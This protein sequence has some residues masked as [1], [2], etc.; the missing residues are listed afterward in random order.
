MKSIDIYLQESAGNDLV[1]FD[2]LESHWNED[3]DK[4]LDKW[5]KTFED[6]ASKDYLNGAGVAMLQKLK[7]LKDTVSDGEESITSIT[8]I[9]FTSEHL[10][11]PG[12]KY[13]LDKFETGI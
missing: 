8:D 4:I 10:T 11:G 1:V 9:D 5:L 2:K 3:K 13:A 7:S 6:L 12:Y